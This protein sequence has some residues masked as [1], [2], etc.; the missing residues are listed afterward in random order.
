MK[1]KSTLFLKIAV[2]LL[3]APVA[4]LGLFGLY[5]LFFHPV[6]PIYAPI[7]YPI[8]AGLYASLVPF[9]IALV[10]TFMLLDNIDKNNA[11]SDFSVKALIRIKYCAAFIAL[12]YAVMMPF[13]FLTAEK[14]DAPGLILVASVPIFTFM[15]VAVFAAVLQRLFAEAAN[16]QSDHDR[17]V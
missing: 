8:I 10:Q 13:V 5:W 14:D 17:V 9:N 16:L 12:L 4:A 2:V 7:L 3:G 15:V 11:F 1:N 6:N